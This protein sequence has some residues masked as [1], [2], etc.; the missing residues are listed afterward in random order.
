MAIRNPTAEEVEALTRGK[1][2]A[3][4]PVKKDNKKVTTKTYDADELRPKSSRFEP[5]PVKFEL[6]SG[7]TFVYQGYLWVRRVNTEEEARLLDLQSKQGSF[8]EVVNSVLSS[9]VKSNFPVSELPLLDKLPLFVFLLS[10][11]F[12]S[13]VNVSDV[14]TNCGACSTEYSFDV[15]LVSDAFYEKI[16]NSEEYPF[17]VQLSSYDEPHTVCFSYPQIK[18]EVN[19]TTLDVSKVLSDL[20]VYLKNSKGHD[21]PKEQY[22]EMFR[23]LNTEDKKSISS[24][25]SNFNSYGQNVK[26]STVHCSNPNCTNEEATVKVESL[27]S[28]ALIGNV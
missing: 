9:A 1:V 3:L 16:P 13:K 10:I 23:W 14:V 19:T 7:N 11:S 8:N 27:F 18:N 2:E 15:N 20:V 12:E 6:P 21:V 5:D 4:Q 17:V 26:F 28:K 22:K 25:I 24:K